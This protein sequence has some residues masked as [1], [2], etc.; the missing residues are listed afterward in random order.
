MGGLC[1]WLGVSA[2]RARVWAAGGWR[3]MCCKPIQAS[4]IVTIYDVLLH[5]EVRRAVCG[6]ASQL[7][8]PGRADGWGI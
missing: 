6:F 5:G 1:T 8:V 7:W 4:R 2:M 3:R